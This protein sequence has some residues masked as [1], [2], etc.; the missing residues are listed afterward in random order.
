MFCGSNQC[1][2]LVC[3]HFIPIDHWSPPFLPSFG[4]VFAECENGDKSVLNIHVCVRNVCYNSIPGTYSLCVLS[5]GKALLQCSLMMCAV[6]E[7]QQ[8]S[9][10][11]RTGSECN[12]L[13]EE[14]AFLFIDDSHRQC[15][16]LVNFHTPCSACA[17]LLDGIVGQLECLD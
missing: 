12:S 14:L 9:D 3:H 1:Q 11:R 16:S 5:I 2:N 10:C 8:S 13:Q 4:Q 7:L 6:V 15:N 17:V